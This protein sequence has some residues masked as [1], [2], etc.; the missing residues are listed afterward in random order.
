M[1]AFPD[2]NSVR[3][4]DTPICSKKKKTKKQTISPSGFALLP[5]QPL[6]ERLF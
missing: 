5:I 1:I 4:L 3:T 6:S 2:F